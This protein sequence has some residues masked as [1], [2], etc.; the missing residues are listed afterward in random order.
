MKVKNSGQFSIA[1]GMIGIGCA[2]FLLF[3]QV[4]RLVLDRTH[5]FWC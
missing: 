3:I 5:S 1:G 2:I 4:N